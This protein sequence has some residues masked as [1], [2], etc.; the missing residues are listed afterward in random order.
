MAEERGY[1]VIDLHE[2]TKN[3]SALFPDGIHPNSKG[4]TMIA[5]VMSK[6]IAGGASAL[7]DE[8]LNDID[9]RYNDAA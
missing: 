7:T 1:P 3:K 6:V 2:I 8:F 5:E 9:A 4:Y